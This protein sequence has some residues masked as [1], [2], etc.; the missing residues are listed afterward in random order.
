M[1]FLL[2]LILIGILSTGLT[3]CST[4]VTYD[5]PPQNISAANSININTASSKE[6]E[7][8]PGIGPKTAAAIVAFR[9][10]N[11]PF[12]RP[13]DLMLIHGVS[14]NRFAEFRQFIR[15]EQCQTDVRDH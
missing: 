8:L 9:E 14:E 15:T 10:E 11:G 6:I 7:K 4:R 2:Y 13:E 1:R 12:R 5:Q 3:S